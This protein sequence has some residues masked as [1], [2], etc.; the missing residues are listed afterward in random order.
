[1]RLARLDE[2]SEQ[3]SLQ[4]LFQN[5]FSS[6]EL[7]FED[8]RVVQRGNQGVFE[9]YV[10]FGLDKLDGGKQSSLAKVLQYV[11]E[12]KGFSMLGTKI[13]R[14]GTPGRWLTNRFI[15]STYPLYVGFFGNP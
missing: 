15:V 5:P 12:C 6:R 13:I 9:L 4:A 10:A 7:P 11:F 3:S 8:D 14:G 1:M 2:R